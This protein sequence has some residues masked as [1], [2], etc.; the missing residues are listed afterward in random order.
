[1]AEAKRLGLV[2]KGVMH[3][4]RRL[5]LKRGLDFTIKREDYPV[6]AFCPVLGIPLDR[7][8]VEHAPSLDR[9][10]NTKGYVDGNVVVISNRANKLKKDATVEELQKLARFYA[11][12]I[13]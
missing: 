12:R 11:S 1:M 7:S 2:T 4:R 6:P 5:A 13:I 10:D 8:D 3:T 9:I